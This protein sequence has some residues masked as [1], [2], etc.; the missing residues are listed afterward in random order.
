MPELGSGIK[1][2]YS[3][4]LLNL[5]SLMLCNQAGDNFPVLP[6]FFNLT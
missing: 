4:F 2:N 3:V 1:K 6:L 5:G